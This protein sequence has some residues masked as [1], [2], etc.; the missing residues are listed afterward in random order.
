MDDKHIGTVV[1]GYEILGISGF[2]EDGH[3]KYFA[4]CLK[5]GYIWNAKLSTIKKI[6]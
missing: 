1:N 2:A 4:K 6:N 3:K 5:C